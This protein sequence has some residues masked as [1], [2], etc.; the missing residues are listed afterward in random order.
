MARTASTSWRLLAAA[1]ACGLAGL[2]LPQLLPGRLP[3]MFTGLLV[4]LGIGLAFAALLAWQLPDACDAA[5]AALRRRYTREMVL[6]MAAYV[7]VLTVSISVLKRV[8]LAPLPR[9]LV[10]LLPVPPIAMSLRAMVR[11]IRDVDEM[12]QRIEL[13]AVSLATAFVALGYMTGG[14]LQSAK[15]IDVPASAAM[16]WVFPLL[17]MAYGLAKAVVARRYR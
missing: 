5:P 8:D 13:E 9:A 12:Q 6:A 7:V 14:F 2:A 3:D 17:C 4:G 16:I 15:V 1:V 10:A 11:Y